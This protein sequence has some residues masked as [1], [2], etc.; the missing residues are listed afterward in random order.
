ML[1]GLAVTGGLV[2]QLGTALN[3]DTMVNIGVAT[4]IL[5]LAVT[6][7]GAASGTG[8]AGQIS[9]TSGLADPTWEFVRAIN[10]FARI[11]GMEVTVEGVETFEQLARVRA[12]GIGQA[13]GYYFSRPMP[14]ADVGD[15]LESE[16]RWSA[17]TIRA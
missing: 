14:A 7:G 9:D 17:A 13:Q 2:E 10:N 5:V 4:S 12:L 8:H 11:L 16:P 3:N 15:F 6:L 1:Y